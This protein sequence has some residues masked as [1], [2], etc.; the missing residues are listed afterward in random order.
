MV[1]GATALEKILTPEALTRINALGDHMRDALNAG[2]KSAGAPFHITGLGSINQIHCTLDPQDRDAALALLSFKLLER[3]FWIAQRGT[4][5]LNFANSE[6]DV[7][8]F[9][10][11]TVEAAKDVNAVAQA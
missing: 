7:D 9:V 1:A 11:A 8:E 5:A 10:A 6:M 3:G 2:F 4:L